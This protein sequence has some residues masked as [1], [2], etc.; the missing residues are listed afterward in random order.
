MAEVLG[1]GSV[2]LRLY[3]HDLPP[4]QLVAEVGAQAGLAEAVG[5]DG[6]MLS[7]HHAGFP[8]YLPNPLLAA[9]WALEAT[10]R[11][12]A[13]ACPMLL[14]LRPVNH[15]IE[16]LAWTA[17]RFPGRVGA[18]FAS[19]ALADDF[20]LS[21]VPFDEMRDRF[22]AALP[23]VVAGLQGRADGLVGADPAVQALAGSPVP[24]VSAAQSPA[25][26]RRAGLLGIGLLFDSLI[27]VSRAAEVSAAHQEAGGGGARILIRRAWLGAPPAEAVDAQM[28]R[29]RRAAS[30]AARDHWGKGDGVVASED[31]TEVAA[32]L[33]SL[34][35]ETG[36]DA[37]N[38]RVFHAGMTPT[39]AR[40]QIERLGTEVLP[41]LRAQMVA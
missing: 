40:S 11:I 35:D 26:A 17:Q 23:L 31:P 1:V 16:D 39:E 41:L 30:S 22:R 34:L 20:A 2:S 18:G 29:Y 7:E 8:N 27:G 36:C 10:Q 5:F 37:L 13:A 33:R 12:W 14:P 4:A 24:V 38:L 3:P 21:G 19:G 25:A 28:D 32:G 6:V 15:V 9:T